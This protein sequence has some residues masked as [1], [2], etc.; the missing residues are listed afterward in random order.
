M[1]H[2]LL[3]F[4][5]AVFAP[6]TLAATPQPP[7]FRLGDLATPKAYE[8]R[9]AADPRS[10][11]FNGEIRI[12][13]T[14]N[15]A[16]PVLWLNATGLTIESARVEQG[17][18]AIDARILPGGEDFIGLESP[19]APFAAGPAAATLR[20]R[21]T[22]EKEAT[23][24][25]FRKSY[26]DVP[27]L[28]TQF[29]EIEARRAF[30]CFDEP[31]W[32]TTWKLTV[33]APADSTV[34]SNT[35]ESATLDTPGK[36]GWRR[37]QFKTTEQLPAYLV[38]FAIGPFD[39]VDGGTAGSKKTPL[40]YIV[41]KGHAA[42]AR[43]VKEAT[44]RI[45]EELEAYFGIPFPFEKL[46]SVAV[47]QFGGG[48]ENAGMITYDVTSVIARPHEE[49]DDTRRRYTSLA[50]HEIAHQWFGDYMT[51]AWWDDTWL[52]EAFAT[53]IGHKT[54]FR[55]NPDWD[56]G[57]E[58]AWSRRRGVDS[59]RLATARRIH[60]PIGDKGDI[61]A[62]F[63]GITY[64][65]GAEV[66]S[67]FE[68]AI[69]PEKFRQ[70]VS[71]YL[72]RYAWA[73]ATSSDFFHAIAEASGS[74]DA[75]MRAFE[76]FI[77]KSGVP[78]VDAKLQCGGEKPVVE[79]TQ[80]RLKPAGSKAPDAQWTTP[81][82]FVYPGKDGSTKTQCTF[83]DGP[84]AR[85]AL[86]DAGSCPAWI[87]GNARG[88]G[89]YVVRYEPPLATAIAKSFSAVGPHEAIAL[90]GDRELLAESGL[91]RIDAA[92]DWADA[93][94]AH[95]SPLVQ[96]TAVILL[97]NLRDAWLG[98]VQAKRKHEIVEG[99]LIPLA[100]KVGW[101]ARPGDG[102]DVIRLRGYLLPFAAQRDEGNGLR[103]EADAMAQA[104]I[105]DRAAVDADIAQ[106]VMNT[107]AR[108]ADERMLKRLEDAERSSTS[109]RDKRTLVKALAV[110][111]EPMRAKALHFTLD[112]KDG[113]D[114]MNGLD[115]FEM[116]ESA[117]EDEANRSPAFAF[118]VTHYDPLVAKI[119][120]DAFV[121]ILRHMDG[122]CTAAE[123]AT[124]ADFF[125]TRAGNTRG[126]DVAYRQTLES[127][128]LC[129][130]ARQQ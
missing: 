37:H 128:D 93:G 20:Y 80:A 87:A 28:F 116:L 78:L 127:I 24:G 102:R 46:D 47:P 16:S 123:R 125:A 6:L 27:Y 4:L 5:T 89:H 12:E 45:L 118:I 105:K 111:R 1:R 7:T 10:D 30:P 3:F 61:E 60:N 107:A 43:L 129:V 99:R 112:R 67:M 44:P 84:S 104:W 66:L 113:Q 124:F 50:A 100:A 91:E 63:D 59:D 65:K 95:P 42:E 25:L 55:V 38:A 23:R 83:I 81:A 41:P 130:A 64:D 54:M 56:D 15:R 51:L 92:L 17:G 18:Q 58:Q 14:F 48:M 68:V 119:P 62:A 31:G 57:F 39:V 70:G 52:N 26:E 115:A 22:L 110:V 21:G 126:G 98:S 36:A 76:G 53:W 86:D 120:P 77:D 101:K 35:F 75:T 117:L 69:G 106:G 29:E 82:C 97:D 9:I 2:A 122:L 33:D 11:A 49:T 74:T 114:A 88:A 108:F 34:I 90:L 8:A 85:L 79:L 94:L 32:K 72:K 109:R 73:S 121:R 19:A 40:R 103:A 96:A 13:L 71:L